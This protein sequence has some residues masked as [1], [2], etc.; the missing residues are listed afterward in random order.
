MQTYKLK[1]RRCE[2]LEVWKMPKW[3]EMEKDGWRLIR[4]KG[5]WRVVNGRKKFE[6]KKLDLALKF[7][8]EKTEA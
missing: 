5:F 6:F 7:W 1:V 8:R 4:E 2:Q 3:L